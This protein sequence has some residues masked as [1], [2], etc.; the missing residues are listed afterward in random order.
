MFVAVKF[1]PADART[2]TYRYDGNCEVSPGDF[3]VVETRDGRRPVEVA[4]VDLPE[5][6]F[7]CKPIIAILTEKVGA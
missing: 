5:P 4:A 1:Q 6:P 2:Y 3:C 7:D